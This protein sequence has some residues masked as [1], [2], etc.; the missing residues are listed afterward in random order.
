M[1]CEIQE[2]LE[3]LP[4][5]LSSGFINWIDVTGFENIDLLSQLGN[6]FNIDQLTMEDMLNVGQLP[7]IEEHEEYLYITLKLVDLIK[8]ENSFE[9]THY[10]LII[11]SNELITF[12]ERPNQQIT[13]IEERLKNNLGILRG[14]GI[15]YLSYG[16]MDNIVDHYY[17]TLDPSLASMASTLGN[18]F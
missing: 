12:S 3:Q 16:I 4:N 5:K 8:E 13:Y 9:F 17:Y 7:K 6:L 14:S 1:L 11:K 2:N 10:S 15:N 18:A